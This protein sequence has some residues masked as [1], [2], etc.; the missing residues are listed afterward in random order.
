MFR[1]S[2][3]AILFSVA[4]LLHYAHSADFTR[5]ENI[6]CHGMDFRGDEANISIKLEYL[7]YT[8]DRQSSNIGPY[9]LHKVQGMSSQFQYVEYFKGVGANGS[10]HNGRKH[11]EH[12]KFDLETSGSEGDMYFE[13]MYLIISPFHK[14][15]KRETS[16]NYYDRSITWYYEARK[17][18]AILNVSWNDHH[19]DYIP[20][21][22]FSGHDIKGHAPPDDDAPAIIKVSMAGDVEQVR[23]FVASGENVNV[24]DKYGKTPLIYAVQWQHSQVV[25]ALLEA[26]ANVN[27]PGGEH[28]TSPLIEAVIAGNE[29]IFSM[30]MKNENI[31]YD[32]QDRYGRTALIWAA[33][34]EKL[35]FVK[36]LIAAGAHLDLIGKDGEESLGKGESAVFAA[37]GYKQVNLD[38][39]KEL[40]MA[41]ADVCAKQSGYTLVDRAE[42]HQYTDIVKMLRRHIK[43][44][45]GCNETS[46]M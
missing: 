36:A 18:P 26:N 15:V 38:I 14:V 20:L 12:L 21:K 45:G 31:N 4:L 35:S 44:V 17:Y 5:I 28:K 24:V 30:L 37:L 19:G 41:G 1:L 43:F 9:T 10:Q 2:L 16:A 22:C 46:N 42:L 33:A 25:Q 13:Y 29:E 11:K 6:R 7:D 39:V 23:A 8:L 27:F 40:L 3:C 34:K 32:L